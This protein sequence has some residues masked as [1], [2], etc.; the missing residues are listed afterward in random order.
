MVSF[1]HYR[2]VLPLD[3]PVL[4]AKM[5]ANGQTTAMSYSPKRLKPAHLDMV[6]MH[7]A[8]DTNADIALKL[9]YTAQQVS[10]ILN[11]PDVLEMLQLLKDESLNTMAQVQAE[12][13]LYAPEILRRK[14]DYALRGDD[15][16]VRNTAQ[17]EILNIAGHVPVKHITVE[18]KSQVVEKYK[19][20][21]EEELRAMIRGESNTTANGKGPDGRLIN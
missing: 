1:Y 8:G 18:N 12:A 15:A 10:N 9:G 17:T 20:K 11:S 21:S 19:D 2:N 4:L 5:A 16:R 14:I 13:Q 3:K 7:L 6:T